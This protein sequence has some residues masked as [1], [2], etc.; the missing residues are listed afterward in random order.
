[1]NVPER[2]VNPA[3]NERLTAAVGILLLAPILVEVATVLLGV[4][5]FMSLH[6]F[7]GLALIPAVLLK[8]ASTGWRFARYYTRSNAYLAQGP[9]QIG[10]R[11]LAPLFVLATVVLLGSGVAMGVLHGHGLQIARRLHGPASVI[12]LVLLG[13]HVLVYIGR[14][15]RRTAEDAVPTKRSPARG[16]AAR[17]YGLAAVVVIGLLLGA[18]TIPAQH[19]WVDLPRDHHDRN[20][21]AG[22]RP[23]IPEAA[24]VAPH[25]SRSDRGA[26]TPSRAN[27]RTRVRLL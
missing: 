9:P 8:L 5:T 13:V 3:G 23:T 2:R 22:A 11:L 4:H 26:V 21:G 16:A 27:V 15:L 17:A 24:T 6:V 10:M 19:R 18:A 14:A 25:R 1:V 12:W 20:R 7:V